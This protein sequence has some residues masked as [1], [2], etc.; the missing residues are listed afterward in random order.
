MKKSFTILPI[1]VFSVSLFANNK[2][3]IS[4]LKQKPRVLTIRNLIRNLDEVVAYHEDFEDGL[5]GWI[6]YDATLPSSTWHLDDY[7]TPDGTGLSW[8]MGNPELGGYTNSLYL[9]LN[10][11]EI[12]VPADG[13]LVFDLNFNV[14][15][16]TGSQSPYDGWDGCN[17]RISVDGGETWTVIE[18]LPAYNCRS[19]YSFG[20]EHGEGPNVPGWGG[21]SYGWITADFD[22]SSFAGQNVMIRFAFA[23]DISYCTQDDP[24]LFGMII[25]N[26]SLGDFSND[27]VEDGMTINSLLPVGGDIWH[28]GEPGDAPSPTHAVILQN[29]QGTYNENML[30][31]LESPLITLP[32]R[33]GIKADFMIK[34][35]FD[36][37]DEFPE[38]DYFG[39]KISPDNGTTWYYM[40]NPY[41]DP[42]QRNYVYAGAPSTWYS[43]TEAYTL[44]GRI[45][46][47][48]GQEVKFRIYFK[49]DDDTPIGTGI[50]IDDFRIYNIPTIQE[51]INEASDGDTVLVQ[52]GTYVENI[53]FNG[54]NIVL[55]SLFLTTRDT[56]YI[57]QTVIDG[58]N[59]GSVVNFERGENYTSVLCGFT[60]TNGFAEWGG[61]I[62]C[63]L[64][65]PTLN[66]LIIKENIG[67]SHGGG[68]ACTL[69]DPI[70]T[71]VIIKNNS[72]N[73]NSG[74]GLVC[75]DASPLLTNVIIT[76]NSAK[77]NGSGISCWGNS[78][79]SFINVNI[80]QNSCYHSGG[81]IGCFGSSRPF[82]GNCILW[83]NEPSEITNMGESMLVVYS[84]IKNGFEGEGNIDTNPLFIDAENGDFHLQSNSPCIDAGTAFYIWEGDTLVNLS[85]D[86]YVGYAPDMGAFEF[87]PYS[88]CGDVDLNGS[89]QAYDASTILKYLVGYLELDHQQLLNANVSSDTTVS[90]LDAY[91]ILQHVVGLITSMPYDTTNGL[92]L[93]S[94]DIEMSDGGIQPGQSAE[95][96]LYLTNVSNILSFEGTVTFK[97]EHLTLDTLI[98]SEI[99]DGLVIETKA[100][101]GEIKFA[102]VGSVSDGQIGVFATLRFTVNENFSESKTAVSLTKIRWN[103]EPIME[104][105]AA[106]RLTN[107]LVGTDF[108]PG[109]PAEFNLSQ[110]YPNPFNPKTTISFQLPKSVFVNLSIYNITGQLVKI[111]IN[112]PKNAGYYNIEWNVKNVD[113]GIYFYRIQAGEFSSVKK[114]IVVK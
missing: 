98:W 40:S 101:N 51:M 102:G 21:S 31:Y 57:S 19:M 22:L 64:S 53:N 67:N 85:T 104:N 50:M 111:L 12:T 8:W 100:E 79:P 11:P 44:D 59:N 99:S 58:N 109:I 30:N 86:D 10:T 49:S 9:V 2:G 91:L 83:D 103:E 108:P 70:I 28:L 14:E 69:S 18:G 110:N 77:W 62:H 47:Y 1:V 95:V 68:I 73:L 20:H 71:N 48:A 4:T 65:D 46:N 94:G 56:S 72:V 54:K 97:P 114:C 43:M 26:I 27:G 42:N 60:I 90:A 88:L 41:G 39:W 89:V 17:V 113:S 29:E 87:V 78:S 33:G 92:L 75:H 5:G 76:N 25:D 23:S 55:A 32:G 13:H 3:N 6:H 61:G 7:D 16:P 35:D 81:G 84:D 96:P 74:A 15:A 80:T 66:N 38:V 106:A 34:G 93:A 52:P 36:D 24:D 37:H 82:L 107:S 45:D 63:W 105:V 112:E